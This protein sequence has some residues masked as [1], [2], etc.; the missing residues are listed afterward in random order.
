[1]VLFTLLLVHSSHGSTRCLSI[2][3]CLDHPNSLGSSQQAPAG[4]VA[5]AKPVLAPSSPRAT[6]R[7]LKPPC[8]PSSTAARF[9]SCYISTGM[10][11]VVPSRK[12][13]L[14][15]ADGSAAQLASAST[16]VLR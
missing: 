9:P 11:P 15:T 4:A 14:S 7:S 1:M 13:R 16:P 5:V 10:V 12:T 2:L 3:L 6:T 8:S